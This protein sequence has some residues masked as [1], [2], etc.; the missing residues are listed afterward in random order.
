MRFIDSFLE[1]F[2]SQSIEVY[3]VFTPTKAAELNY[4][5]RPNLEKQ[6]NQ[7]LCTPGKQILLFGHSGSGKT[8]IIRSLLNNAGQNSI[9]THCEKATTYEQILMN[10]FDSL[11]KYIQ[12]EKSISKSHKINSD[13]MAEFKL[14][15]AGIKEETASVESGKYVRL[16]PPQL[17][18]QK[19]AHF[20]GEG[21]FNWIIEDFH[22]VEDVEKKRIADILKIFSDNA[23]EYQ[24]VKVICIGACDSANDLVR[25]E[26]DLKGR[27]AEIKVN[28]LSEKLIREIVI[29][30]CKLLNIEMEDCLIEKL[31]Y[32]SARLGSS[33][34]QMC[35]NICLGNNITCR[36]KKKRK[37]YDKSFN[38]A[39]EGFIKSNEGTLTTIYDSAVRNA[40]GWY[41]L[42]TFSRNCHDKLQF[43]EIKKIVNKSQ[44]S[45]TDEE[46][47]HK[48]GEL[49]S[50]EYGVIYFNPITE[51]YTLSSPFWKAFLRMQ[52]AIEDAERNKANKNKANKNLKLIDQNDRDASVESLMLELLQRFKEKER[53]SN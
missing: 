52:F 49:S 11:D 17:T 14:F 24:K 6:I 39:V 23:N 35:L 30:G 4:I 36:Q 19:L 20:L 13:F 32:Y 8:T 12:S 25:L 33:V 47:K 48:L 15:K 27:V 22:K 46:I 10:A 45:F 28:L 53:L 44:Q 40:L 51:N 1:L 9:R 16:L 18:P 43:R 5:A 31:V 2:S 29:N 37:V 21:G 38:Y 7:E 3:N 34:H 41:I 50:P 26:P 42:K